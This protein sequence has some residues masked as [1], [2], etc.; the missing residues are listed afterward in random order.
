[1]D[2][3]DTTL[4]NQRILDEVQPLAR[5]IMDS[6]LE[7]YSERDSYLLQLKIHTHEQ[8]IKTTIA[9]SKNPKYAEKK[10]HYGNKGFVELIDEKLY[11]SPLFILKLEFHLASREIRMT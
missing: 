5:R 11:E 3:E 2:I 10:Q 6:F 9:D 7:K 1:M 8:T 4:R